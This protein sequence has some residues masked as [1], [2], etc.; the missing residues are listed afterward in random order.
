MSDHVYKSVELTGSSPDGIQKAIENAIGRAGETIRNV[1]WFE[2]A[3]VRGQVE[4]GKIAHWQVTMKVGFT[5]D[6]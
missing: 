3:Q 1:R 5:L 6:D 4:G 2:I